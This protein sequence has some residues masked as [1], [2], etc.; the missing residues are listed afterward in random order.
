MQTIKMFKSFS[1]AFKGL[2][3]ALNENNFRFH[4]LATILVT[5]CGV[6]FH[7]SNPEWLAII[8]CC[9]LVLSM[10]I[11][12]TAIEK[13]IDIISPEFHKTAGMV[14]DLAAAAVLMMAIT[15]F[16]VFLTIFYKYI[17]CVIR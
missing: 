5:L 13:M 14:K 1:F 3:Y 16:V 8:L 15:S 7:I 17:M 12:N 11:I 9:G 10:E 4:I 2:K 6:C